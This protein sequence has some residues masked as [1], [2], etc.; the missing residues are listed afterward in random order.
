M[1]VRPPFQSK[2][3]DGS[4]NIYRTKDMIRSKVS[5]SS[6]HCAFCLLRSWLLFR[7]C[8]RFLFA[9]LLSGWP[10][11]WKPVT[12]PDN[13]IKLSVLLRQ[14]WWSW[15]VIGF[16]QNFESFWLANRVSFFH[17]FCLVVDPSLPLQPFLVLF[18]LQYSSKC[19]PKPS[20]GPCWGVS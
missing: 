15:A 12:E 14:T 7:C 2:S 18:N 10:M 20:A 8:C 9:S 3:V 1:A 19:K 6:P 4:M 13:K 17:I 16:W 11:G 5:Y